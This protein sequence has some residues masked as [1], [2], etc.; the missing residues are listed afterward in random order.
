[1]P[2]GEQR[3]QPTT[4]IVETGALG[5]GVRKSPEGTR[6]RVCSIHAY[7]VEVPRDR[8]RTPESTKNYR[9]MNYVNNVQTEKQAAAG[10][11][12]ERAA[13]AT[14]RG[15]LLLLHARTVRYRA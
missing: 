3:C 13:A 4:T 14:H 10:C 8:R 5:C 9:K 1:M 11:S 15:V 6:Q 7:R 2:A 12:F